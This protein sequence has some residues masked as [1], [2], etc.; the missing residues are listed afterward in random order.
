M[1]RR[2]FACIALVELLGCAEP[3]GEAPV[4]GQE[5]RAESETPAEP[6]P[7]TPEGD[8]LLARAR[9]AIYGGEVPAALRRELLAS[10][11]PEHRRAARLLQAVAGEAPSETLERRGVGA[12]RAP[13]GPAVMPALPPQPGQR[14]QGAEFAESTEEI[15]AKAPAGEGADATAGD[16]REP[17]PARGEASDEP[18][19]EPQS[20]DLERLPEGSSIR[21]FYGDRLALAAIEAE[22][23]GDAESA[24]D[25]SE[26]WGP[27]RGEAQLLLAQLPPAPSLSEAP[28]E[29]APHRDPSLARGLVILTGLSLEGEASEGGV[30][31]V[32][33][34]A[35]PVTVH[36][37]VLASQRLLLWIDGAGAMPTFTGA[38]PRDEAALVVLEVRRDES[39]VELELDLAPGWEL[40]RS[41]TRPNGARLYFSGRLEGE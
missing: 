24:G 14:A 41:E 40:A 12:P 7:T 19:L 35:A 38:R 17:V 15:G 10:T 39:R 30:E 28:D 2:P 31:L 23:S 3:M 13:S 29:L 27:L 18:E 33:T 9:A 21:Q 37:R 16:P 6:E 4:G 36:S 25:P 5:A 20:W 32:L 11:D 22:V 34:G 8:P 26:L 1:P